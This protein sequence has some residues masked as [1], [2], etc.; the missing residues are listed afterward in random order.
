MFLILFLKAFCGGR[1]DSLE[2]YSSVSNISVTQERNLP[3]ISSLGIIFMINTAI[4]FS[5]FFQSLVI[6]SNIYW[7]WVSM[8]SSVYS[9][10]IFF[11]FL[12]SFFLFCVKVK[13]LVRVRIFATPGTRLFC[14]WDFPGKSTG[15]GCHFLLQEIFLTQGSNPGLSHCR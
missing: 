15:V 1:E 5:V 11:F 8:A 9:F 13:S 12:L 4:Y 2:Y 3:H 6:F 14:P 7:L 10:P